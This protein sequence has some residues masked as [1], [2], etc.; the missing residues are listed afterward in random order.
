M[1]VV[2]LLAVAGPEVVWADLFVA[3]REAGLRFGWLEV[4]SAVAVDPALAAGAARVVR[5]GEEATV[6][7][8]AR[9]GP[10]V[11]ADVVRSH[12]LGCDA[13]LVAGGAET[14]PRLEHAEDGNWRLAVPGEPVRVLPTSG[15]LAALRRPKLARHSWL[16]EPAAE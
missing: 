1:K 5:L 3:A 8:S 6:A 2:P 10:A 15:L 12:F 9:R 14:L 7:A 13:V 11:L 16:R 4:G